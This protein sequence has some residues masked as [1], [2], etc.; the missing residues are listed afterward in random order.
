MNIRTCDILYL[1]DAKLLLTQIC[2]NRGECSC[3]AGFIGT[4]CQ[5]LYNE[6]PRPKRESLIE[7]PCIG[8]EL[9]PC[10]LD[11]QSCLQLC[12]S[13]YSLQGSS[14]VDINECGQ[15]THNCEQLCINTV[16]SFVCNC[17]SGY[18]L[19]SDG[20]TCSGRM[21]QHEKCALN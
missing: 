10:L 9:D 21:I 8:I 17:R 4:I 14:C 7:Q 5:W 6:H 18:R 19:S 1:Q 11:P 2:N 12:S 15:G 3:Y 16:G 20:R 13:G